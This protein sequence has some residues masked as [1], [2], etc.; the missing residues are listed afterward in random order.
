MRH[1]RPR[2]GPVR[3]PCHGLALTVSVRAVVVSSFL[4]YDMLSSSIT[5]AIFKH[6]LPAIDTSTA[7]MGEYGRLLGK[8]LEFIDG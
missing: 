2:D 6:R 3:D 5:Q 4:Y 1:L 8:A 7:A